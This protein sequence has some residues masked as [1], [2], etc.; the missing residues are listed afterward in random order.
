MSHFIPQASNPKG[1]KRDTTSPLPGPSGVDQ[2]KRDASPPTPTTL[3]DGPGPSSSKVMLLSTLHTL[4][5]QGR[6]RDVTPLLRVKDPGPSP[7]KARKGDIHDN[8]Q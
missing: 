8:I 1:R 7:S 3:S 4:Q 5:L 6:K 2:R